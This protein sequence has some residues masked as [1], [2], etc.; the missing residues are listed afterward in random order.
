MNTGQGQHLDI[1]MTDGAVAFNAM[2]AAQYLA[3]G[4]EAGRETWQLNG[5]SVYDFYECA[6]GG[7]ISFGGLEPKFN[8]AFFNAIGL[9]DLIPGGVMPADLSRVKG[10]VAGRI[11]EKTRDE[12]AEVFSK[13][14]ACVEPVLS[15]AEALESDLARSR[16]WVREVAKPGGGSARQLG[17]PFK[18]SAT[19]PSYGQIGSVAGAH[20]REIMSELGYGDREIAELEA[21]G[22]F[23]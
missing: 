1:S 5:G 9:P 22:L 17:L 20:S 12:W 14:D 19:P 16:G 4:R 3:E 23:G 15:L 18:F 13:V 7:F 2:A 8:A 21:D 11:K 10:L 6:D